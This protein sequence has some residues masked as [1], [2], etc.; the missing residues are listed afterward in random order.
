MKNFKPDYHL[1]V[2]G[3][4]CPYPAVATLDA[5]QQLNAGDILEVI[6]DCPQSIN[7]IPQNAKNHGYSV[8]NIQQDGPMIYYV[9]QK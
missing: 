4:T 9:L 5:M 2:T 8:L 1:D 6:S 7:N 3:E